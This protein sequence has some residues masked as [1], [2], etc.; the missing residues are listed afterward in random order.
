[1]QLSV[2]D[3]TRGRVMALW[4]MTLSASAPVGHL[5]AGAA[6][7]VVPVRDVLGWMAVGAIAVA[8]GVVGLATGE[9]PRD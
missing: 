4:A 5:A 6:A 1:M 3:R 2:D 9:R 7:T 8:V